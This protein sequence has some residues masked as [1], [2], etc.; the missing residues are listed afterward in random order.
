METVL[1]APFAGAGA[2]AAGDDR[3]P[4]RDRRAAAAPGADRPRRATDAEAAASPARTWSCRRRADRRLRR[5]A[6][7]PRAAPTCAACCSASTSTADDE[8]GALAGYLAARERG[9]TDGHDVVGRRGRAARGVRRP[10]RAEPQPARPARSCSTEL[11]VH[12]PR[13]YFH[14]YLQSLDVERAGLPDAFRD[15]LARVLA[16]YGVDDLERTPE[17]EEAVFRIFLAQQRTSADVRVVVAAAAALA[18]RAAA[19]GGAARAGRARSLERLVRATQLRFPVVGDLARSVG[20]A[21]STSRWSPQARRGA[22]RCPRRARGARRRPRRGRP[23]RADR[24]AGRDPRA[25]GAAS[26]AERLGAR[27]ARRAS[28]CSRCWSGGTTAST[29][30][31][32]CGSLDG[33][34]AVRGRRLRP[35]RDRPTRLVS[36][37]GTID[38]LAD[39]AGPLA[40]AIAAQVAARPTRTQSSST[41]TSP[42]PTSREPA[43]RP[44]TELAALVGAL[45]FAADVRRVAV[46]VCPGGG[47]AGPLLHLPSRDR[48]RRDRGRGRPGPRPA[49]DGRP[50]AAACGGCATSTSPGCDGR[51]GRLLYHCVAPDNPADERLV[52]MA[53]VRELRR[54]RDADGRRPRAARTPSVPSR[55][56]WRR[57]GGR[58]PARRRPA[59]RST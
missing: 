29:T 35:R 37:L 59:P 10:G 22:R 26:S 52:A 42:G 43:A 12:S 13:E 4:G 56:A 27:R 6:G 36:T 28:R 50:P 53:Q 40:T 31:T 14:T 3:Q 41:S 7:R 11:R 58:A 16:H 23:R 30:C 15:R 45:P 9:R 25:D 38:E 18:R 57:S 51:R 1:R 20:S 44:A 49:P 34:P 48:R 2:R 54:V 8:A 55:T 46:A 5:R 21:G 32:T 39:P 19:G 33:R 17:L 24:R 47:D